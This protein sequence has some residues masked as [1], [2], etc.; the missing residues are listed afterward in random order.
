M[1]RRILF[2]CS[3]NTCRSPLAEAF[4]RSEAARRGAS[5][6]LASSA[7]TFALPGQPA[8][9][10]AVKAA[11][12]HGLDLTAHRSRPLT[13]E[14]VASADLVVGMTVDHLAAVRRLSESVPAVLATEYLPADHPHSRAGVPD[15]FG[16]N[17]QVYGETARLLAACVKGLFDRLA[18][19]SR[20]GPAHG[21]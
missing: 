1:N 2:V 21:R 16:G 11:S 9:G 12:A 5:H 3:G 17:D 15:P 6:T 19:P 14:L 8:T 7:G 4:A 20:E 13:A 10:G 18:G